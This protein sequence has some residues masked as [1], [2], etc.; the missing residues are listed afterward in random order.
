MELSWEKLARYS[1]TNDK[2][3]LK[4]RL[5]LNEAWDDGSIGVI[6]GMCRKR[7][8]LRISNEKT[9]RALCLGDKDFEMLPGDVMNLRNLQILILRDNDLLT[10]P[11]E[12]GHLTILKKLHIQGNKLTV[13]PPEL[14]ALDLIENK[15]VLRLEYNPWITNIQVRCLERDRLRSN[16]LAN[17]SNLSCRVLL[18]CLQ[19]APYLT[20]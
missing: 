10:I 11:R 3:L 13:L 12:I 6:S 19:V 16:P 9:L 5:K 2:M 14:G 20:I 7:C 1:C 15:Q 17:C 18:R 8:G 4:R